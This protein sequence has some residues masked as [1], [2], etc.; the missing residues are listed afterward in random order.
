MMMQPTT[1]ACHT[2][3]SL[4]GNAI[5]SPVTVIISPY[6]ATMASHAYEQKS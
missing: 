1:I 5:G 4:F 6:P 2:L 3:V